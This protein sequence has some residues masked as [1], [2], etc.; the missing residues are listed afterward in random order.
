[1]RTE[2]LHMRA[3]LLR[4][5]GYFVLF[6]S[7][8]SA[9]EGPLP[10]IRRL[11]A[12][13]HW[14]VASAEVKH[15]SR[16]SRVNELRERNGFHPTVY[17]EDFQVAL[18]LPAA[19]CP[20]PMR[21]VTKGGDSC[22]G[23]YITLETDSFADASRWGLRHPIRSAVQVHYDPSGAAGNHV[24]FMGESA[25]NIYPWNGIAVSIG[26]FAFAVLLF[27]LAART[28]AK[29]DKWEILERS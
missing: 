2:R 24:F 22:V 20:P 9:L 14:P 8:I 29:A 28:Y 25:K 4:F 21:T 16:Q 15:F 18:D 27:V 10:I 1:M 5:G 6:G 7:L 26:I 13:S 17:W 12:A 19:Q 11:Y 3:K 23:H